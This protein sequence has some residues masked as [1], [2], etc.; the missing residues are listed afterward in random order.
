MTTL[1]ALA[2]TLDETALADVLASVPDQYRAAT[3]AMLA[4]WLAD[5]DWGRGGHGT[6]TDEEIASELV[7]GRAESRAVKRAWVARGCVP[8][9]PRRSLSREQVLGIRA[10]Y[11]PRVVGYLRLARKY[12]TSVGVVQRVIDGTTYQDV[13]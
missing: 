5:P 4:E 7:A 10:D 2:A 9:P 11:V 6:V 3:T 1:T 13:R 8:K 12:G